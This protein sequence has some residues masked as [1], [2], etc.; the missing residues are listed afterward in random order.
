VHVVPGRLRHGVRLLRDRLVRLPAAAH[1]GEIV[2]QYRGARR[3]A[4]EHDLGAI[5]NI[6]FMGMGE[7]LA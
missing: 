4:R 7:P 6:V 3:W 2:A 1:P 5:T